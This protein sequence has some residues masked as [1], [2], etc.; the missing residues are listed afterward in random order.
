MTAS[1]LFALASAAEVGRW[2]GLEAVS[3]EDAL[4]ELGFAFDPVLVQWSH[5]GEPPREAPWI[6]IPSR[7]FAGGLRF[8]LAEDDAIDLVEAL[9]PRTD[10]GAALRASDLGPAD[11]VL[12]LE[13]E[14]ITIAGGESVYAE[15]GLAVRRA[16]EGGALLALLGFAPTTPADYI[17]RL[18]PA[19][20]R[21]RPLHTGGG[22]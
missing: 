20:D 15:R 17:E 14:G 3:A 8:W 6:G 19:P 10:D 2:S 22:S 7:R 16:P 1:T 21:P 12:D 4:A 5:R 9:H 11:V 18:R 13:V